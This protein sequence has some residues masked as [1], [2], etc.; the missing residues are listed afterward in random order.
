[1]RLCI[2]KN[3]GTEDS[4]VEK[5]NTVEKMIKLKGCFDHDDPCSLKS[6]ISNIQLTD[7]Q[8]EE[9]EAM[10]GDGVLPRPNATFNNYGNIYYTQMITNKNLSVYKLEKRMKPEVLQ[11]FCKATDEKCFK[12]MP[13]VDMLLR[14]SIRSGSDNL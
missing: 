13:K 4:I 8:G 14:Y 12:F 1:M 7:A 3:T 6:T 9:V 10:T 11:K 5:M 2:R